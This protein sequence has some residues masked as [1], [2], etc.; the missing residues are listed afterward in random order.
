[1]WSFVVT[2][3][4]KQWIWLALDAKT[5]EIVGVH[6]G[7]RSREGAKKLWQS[8]PPVYRQCAVCYSDFWEAYEQVIPSKRHQAVG[9]ETGKTNYIERFNCTLR[10]SGFSFSQEDSFILQKNRKSYWGNLVLCPSLQCILT[11]LGLPKTKL[12][13][14]HNST[15]F[16]FHEVKLALDR[17]LRLCPFVLT[18]G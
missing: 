12:I 13:I 6:I 15:L 8:L 4:N 10:S 9:K 2:K 11:S 5:R 17:L 18:N 1:M 14:D 16:D 7:D 3:S